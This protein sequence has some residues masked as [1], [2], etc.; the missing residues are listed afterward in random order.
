MQT[1]D[2]ARQLRAD[3]HATSLEGKR[4]CDFLSQIKN[5][6]D[7]LSHV[8]SLV[9]HEEY[10]DAILKILPHDY[11]LVDFVIERKFISLS[12]VQVKALLLTHE[13][14]INRYRKHSFSPSVNYTYG[15]V[16][17]NSFA[18]I[19]FD[20]Y[21]GGHSGGYAHRGRNHG[22]NGD[23]GGASGG[24]HG[25]GSSR[26]CGCHFANFQCQI[27]L[28]MVTLLISITIGLTPVINHMNL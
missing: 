8:G 24:H 3:L 16:N 13:S 17:P 22:G 5:I 18:L 9:E 25:G 6:V 14:H 26:N 10:V 20:G 12:I 19:D 7:E 21:C 27:C 1:K 11:A 28:S 2:C 15:Y 4:M 23:H